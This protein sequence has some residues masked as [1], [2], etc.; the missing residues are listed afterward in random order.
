MTPQQFEEIKTLVRDL[1]TQSHLAKGKEVSGLH[2]EINNKLNNLQK[3]VQTMQVDITEAKVFG[4]EAKAFIEE[5][6]PAIQAFGMVS[7]TTKVS[8]ILLVA[9]A[10]IAGGILGIKEI[11]STLK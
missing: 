10:T 6:K 4:L 7:S 2:S 11:Y 1:I 9:L 8:G 5:A 3:D